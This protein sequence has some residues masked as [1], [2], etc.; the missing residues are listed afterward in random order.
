MGHQG[1]LVD[2]AQVDEA[3]PDPVAPLVLLAECGKKL[4]FVDHP[5]GDEQVPEL[6]S[7]LFRLH[8]EPSIGATRPGPYLRRLPS[9]EGPWTRREGP[10]SAPIGPLAARPV[11][12]DL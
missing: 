11:R 2:E 4:G 6:R 1:P 9:R 10:A 8:H 3:H 5:G 7:G 12:P